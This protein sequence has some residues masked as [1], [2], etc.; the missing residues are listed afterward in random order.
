MA[1]LKRNHWKEDSEFL[2]RLAELLE[3]GF[4]LETAI[5]YL[6]ITAKHNKKRYL[7]ITDYLNQ[8]IAFSEALEKCDFPN[9][10]I[11]PIYF[12][13]EHGYFSETIRDVGLLTE[14]KFTQ[15]KALVKTIQY[16]AILLTT[17]LL[18]FILLRLFLMPKFELLFSQLS[19]SE[20]NTNQLS[21][22]LF[23]RLPIIL[24]SMLLFFGLLT[25]FLHHKF[26]K[27]P[28]RKQYALISRIPFARY[29]FQIHYSQLFARECGYL[30]QSGLSIQKI[31]QLFH[32]SNTAGFFQEISHDLSQQLALGKSFSESLATLPY[33]EKEFIQVVKH[34]E[35]NGT[36]ANELIFYYQQCQ[37]RLMERITQILSWI[38]PC[39]FL[40]IGVFII[41]IYLSILLPM[42]SMVDKI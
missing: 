37:T 31:F 23:D 28:L 17:V 36:L 9:F 6:S 16:P 39:V 38:Q 3:K 32:S 4:P 27:Y 7:R 15:Q 21:S 33:L 30:L 40:F 19:Q 42:F 20:S 8:G 26:Q 2:I 11:A 5:N 14:Q 1:I 13:T 29:F 35:R 18:V 24:L 22:F 10:C 41:S 25:V 34:G 12:S